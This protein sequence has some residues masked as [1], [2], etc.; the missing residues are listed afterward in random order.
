MLGCMVETSVGITAAASLAS[1]VDKVDLDGNLLITN[2][3]YSGVK[4][5]NGYLSLQIL[6]V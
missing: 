6:W 5:I 4:V 3:P 1:A 2:D